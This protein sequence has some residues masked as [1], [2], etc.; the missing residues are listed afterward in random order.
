MGLL[1]YLIMEIASIQL[2]NSYT[3]NIWFAYPSNLLPVCRLCSFK[4]H[5]FISKSAQKLILIPIWAVHWT[6]AEV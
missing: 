6:K 2:E 3:A 5:V 1:Q 4:I